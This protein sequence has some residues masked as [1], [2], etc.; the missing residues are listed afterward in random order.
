MRPSLSIFVFIDAFGWEILKRHQSFMA[1]M[2]PYRSP[3]KSVF[4]Y[5]S[6]CN[7]TILTGLM[8]HEHGHFSFFFYNQGRSPIHICR[9]LNYLP[10]SITQRGRIRRIMSRVI[11]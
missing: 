4:G 7:P 8:P 2:L 10:Y 11:S 1:E 3:L 6:T 9:Y 5:S